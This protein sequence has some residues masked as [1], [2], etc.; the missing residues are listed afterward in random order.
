MATY[1]GLIK[2]LLRIAFFS[3]FLIAGVSILPL[4]Q[5]LKIVSAG[6]YIWVVLIITGNIFLIWLINIF[7]VYV[8]EKYFVS[9]RQQIIR[10]VLSFVISVTLSGFFLL[11]I[12]SFRL[13]EMY[14]PDEELLRI[15]KRHR[16]A[17]FFSSL[18]SNAFVLFMQEVVLLREKKSRIELEFAR[19]KIENSRAVNQQLK[20]HIH[21]H[22]LFNSLSILK[23]LIHKDPDVAEEYVIRLSDFLRISISSNES[24]VVKLKDELKM[25]DDFVEMQKIRF[26]SALR[27]VNQISADIIATGFV[28]GF[29]IQL[30]LE[31]AIKHN[32]LTADAPLIIHMMDANGWLVV[33]NNVQQKHSIEDS[34]KSG[35]ANLSE[36]YKI[37]SGHDIQV[38]NNG[39]SFKV[40]I[41]ILNNANSNH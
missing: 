8:Q 14:L 21:P 4:F 39:K 26:G 19:L 6:F 18:F 40:S 33:E 1:N 17:P 35:L 12:E 24:N 20:Q 34:T 25:C 3:S 16:L 32:A 11:F 22:F 5:T 37:L 23:S 13:A 31:N 15:G 7:L 2:K 28:P 41:K 29:S 38:E 10:Y 36:R 9:S 27:V 30:L